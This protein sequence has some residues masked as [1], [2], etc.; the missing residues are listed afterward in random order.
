MQTSVRDDG[1][2][3]QWKNNCMAMSYIHRNC[4]CTTSK[5]AGVCVKHS[6][7]IPVH[8]H[9]CACDN[10]GVL[11]LDVVKSLLFSHTHTYIRACRA[12]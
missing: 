6:L 7:L 8:L 4:I 5:S 1:G 11:L 3:V 2:S 10:C 12:I 9:V